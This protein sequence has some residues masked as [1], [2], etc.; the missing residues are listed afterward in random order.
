VAPTDQRYGAAVLHGL[1]SRQSNKTCKE[2][3]DGVAARRSTTVRDVV[4]LYMAMQAC[5]GSLPCVV[6]R[7]MEGVGV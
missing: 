2:A 5:G 6:A 1:R 7:K 4:F 3:K